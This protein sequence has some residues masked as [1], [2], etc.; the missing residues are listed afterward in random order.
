MI[1]KIITCIVTCILTCT[2]VQAATPE[3][4]TQVFNE[5]TTACKIYKHPCTITPI[6]DNKLWAQTRSGGRI[7]V[8]TK[9]LI[10]MNESQVRGVIY[11]EVGHVVLEH[12]EKTAEYLYMSKLNKDYN[13]NFFNSFRRQNELQADRFATYLGL[14]TFKETDL[15]GALIILTPTDQFYKTHISHP[16]TADRI[17]QIEQ[18]LGR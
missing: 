2:L 17:Q 9:L 16:S 15:I 18:I 10:T 8:S 5:A 7:E 11:H 14:F 3:E 6:E 13:E 1:K 12:I 4:Y